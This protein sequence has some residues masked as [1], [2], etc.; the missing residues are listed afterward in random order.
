M[1][2]KIAFGL[3]AAFF[4]LIT[5]CSPTLD[6]QAEEGPR[7]RLTIEEA[8]FVAKGELFRIY[9]EDADPVIVEVTAT[10]TDIDGQPGWRLDTLVHVLVNNRTRNAAN[11]PGQRPPLRIGASLGNSGWIAFGREAIHLPGLR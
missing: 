5:P 10:E 3:A 7:F 4:T 8:G 1:G 2:P 11:D 9:G 6:R